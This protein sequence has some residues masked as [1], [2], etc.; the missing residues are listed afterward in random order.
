MDVPV[1]CRGEIRFTFASAEKGSSFDD[2][3]FDALIDALDKIGAFFEGGSASRMDAADVVPDSPL[4]L[5]VASLTASA[6]TALPS[7]EKSG[8]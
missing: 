5:K 3:V 6:T 7:P 1:P 2:E 8:S 4:A